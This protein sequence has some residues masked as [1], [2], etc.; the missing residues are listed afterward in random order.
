VVV[1]AVVMLAALVVLVVVSLM[2]SITMS[3]FVLCV[4]KY[5]YA[6][7]Y[8]AVREGQSKIRHGRDHVI[9]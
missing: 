4:G 9:E 5:K 6:R 8:L 2:L 1:V 7:T 3:D